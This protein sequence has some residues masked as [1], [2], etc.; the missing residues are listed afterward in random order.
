MRFPT[1]RN[2]YS[3]CTLR[4]IN[5]GFLTNL[6]EYD[7][8]DFFLFRSETSRKSC[9]FQNERTI[10]IHSYSI[11]FNM[12][13]ESVSMCVSFHHKFKTFI[14]K[15]F[16][17]YIMKKFKTKKKKVLFSYNG[18]MTFWNVPGIKSLHNAVKGNARIFWIENRKRGRR[19]ENLS[20]R[21]CIIVISSG[22]IHKDLYERRS[23]RV[24]T[25]NVHVLCKDYMFIQ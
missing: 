15:K 11:Q 10:L 17:T 12:K 7:C 21:S 1:R 8:K 9:L 25:I 14:M 6:M 23:K 16:K 18:E 13:H 4:K 20:Y 5:Q 24:N 19:R 2:T 22:N 3:I